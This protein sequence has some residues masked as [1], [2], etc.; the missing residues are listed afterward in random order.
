MWE[1]DRASWDVAEE[2]L[3]LQEWSWRDKEPYFLCQEMKKL[4]DELLKIL[5]TQWNVEVVADSS[6]VSV[7]K[8]YVKYTAGVTRGL[9]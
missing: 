1:E 5:F 4:F 2:L 7:N 6:W 3:W 9:E 8:M